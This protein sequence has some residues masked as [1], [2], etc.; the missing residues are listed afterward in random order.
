MTNTVSINP[1]D[2][3]L[4]LLRE[5]LKR[6][7]TQGDAL[8]MA[9]DSVQ[10]TSKQVKHVFAETKKLRSE[11][12]MMHDSIESRITLS[13]SE[14]Y[15]LQSLVCKRSNILA[16]YAINVLHGSGDW[17]GDE[18]YLKKV[19]QIRM[20]LYKHLKHHFNVRKYSLILEKDYRKALGFLEEQGVD[21]LNQNEFRDT[22]TQLE[23]LSASNLTA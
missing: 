8:I 15:T 18:Y 3:N 13:E 1:S 11:M 17:G 21:S 19:G 16:R 12:Q 5:T 6:Q 7:N 2:G 14:V 9:I 10:K 20:I 23:L 22:P 4:A